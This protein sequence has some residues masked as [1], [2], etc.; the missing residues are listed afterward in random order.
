MADTTT[1][2]GF[3]VDLEKQLNFLAVKDDQTIRQKIT[4]LSSVRQI[5]GTVPGV[6]GKIRFSEMLVK[7]FTQPYQSGWQKKGGIS[8]TP[9]EYFVKY[10]KVNDDFDPLDLRNSYLAETLGIDN[11]I[12][13]SQKLASLYFNAMTTGVAKE[14]DECLINGIYKKPTK[15]V[16][17][18]HLDTCDGLKQEIRNQRSENKIYVFKAGVGVEMTSENI[19]DLISAMYKEIPEAQ[20]QSADLVCYMF[21]NA[22]EMYNDW[23]EDKRG[24][25]T[26]YSGIKYTIP[27]TDVP[28]IFLPYGNGSD[29]VLFTMK[30]NI[31]CFEGDPSDVKRT[32][33]QYIKDMMHTSMHYGTGIGFVMTADASQEDQQ[34]AWINECDFVKQGKPDFTLDAASNITAN[35]ATISGTVSG[36][37][38]EVTA[39]GFEYKPTASEDWTVSNV[40]PDEEGVISKNL[41]GLTAETEYDFRL[42]VQ[43]AAGKFYSTTTGKFTT[44]AV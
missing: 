23:F 6:K 44:L 12:E 1:N 28:I 39:A 13:L 8:F 19:G 35:S 36:D 33:S 17:G 42:F 24:L 3:E 4:A 22:K 5:F 10:G 11:S 29:M 40:V 7:K 2:P 27:K 34:W 32:N 9:N 14:V 43:T 25:M 37:D 18:S 41:A 21:N 38:F 26:D 30:D 15:D 16:P 20:R 31:K